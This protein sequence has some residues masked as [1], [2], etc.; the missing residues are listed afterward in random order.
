LGSQSVVVPLSLPGGGAASPKLPLD[1]LPPEEVPPE[2]LELPPLDVD[3]P[4]ELPPEP[5]LVPWSNPEPLVEPQAKPAIAMP[6]QNK[7]QAREL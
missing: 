4:P 1:P 7:G 5:L 6:A 2:P 3:P